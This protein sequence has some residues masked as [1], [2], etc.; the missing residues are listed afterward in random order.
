MVGPDFSSPSTLSVEDLSYSYGGISALRHVDMSVGAGE[1]CCV[2]GP[3]GAGKTT[4][5]A[6]LAGV[7]STPAGTVSMDGGD[8]SGEGVCERARRG[9][10]YVPEGG[11]VFP[12][13]SVVENLSVG[14]TSPSKRAGEILEQAAQHFPFLTARRRQRAGLLSG[15]EQRMLALARILVTKPKLTI[16]DEL[17][18]GLAPVIVEQLFQALDSARG[19]TTFVLI[20]QYLERAY[21]LADRLLVLSSGNV[22]YTGQASGITITEVETMYSLRASIAQENRGADP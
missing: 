10:A 7:L 16:I 20:E 12:S 22:L 8:V 21:G 18:H 19:I 3:N 11:A 14:R 13:L 2:L 4:L 5:G 9:V 17:S 6:A 1:I 15:G